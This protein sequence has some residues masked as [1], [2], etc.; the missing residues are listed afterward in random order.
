MPAPTQSIIQMQ[1]SGAA[2]EWTDVSTDVWLADYPLTL[3]YG[4]PG[5]SP[6]DRVAETGTCTFALN[7]SARNTAKIAGYYS[8]GG[9]RCRPGFGYGIGVRVVFTYLGVTYYKFRGVIDAIQPMPGARGGRITVCTVVD[10]IDEAARY[11]LRGIPAQVDQ[12]SDEVVSTILAEMPVQPAATSIDTGIDTFAYSLDT[13]DD[14]RSTA[15]SEFQKIAQ[16]EL[17]YI[18]IKGDSTQGGTLVFENRHHRSSVVTNAVTLSDTMLAMDVVR[19]RDELLNTVTVTVQPRRVGGSTVVLFTLN[20][21]VVVPPNGGTITLVCPYSDPDN[22]AEQIGG[23]NMIA[24]VATTDYTAVDEALPILAL[25]TYVS[26]AATFGGNSASVLFT[27]SH[28]TESALIDFFQLRGEGVFAFTSES[29]L[30]KA[31][32]TTSQALL[33]ENGLSLDMPY[34]S[35]ANTGQ[36]AANYLLSLYSD[37]RTTARSVTFLANTS[38]ALLVAALAREIGDRVGIE[39][40]VTGLTDDVEWL[41]QELYEVGGT[42]PLRASSSIQ[43]VAQGFKCNP[44]A[45]TRVEFQFQRIGVPSGVVWAQIESD[46]AG[47]PSGTALATSETIRSID[48]QAGD[49]FWTTFRFT[50]PYTVASASTQYHLVL[51]STCSIDGTNYFSLSGVFGIGLYPNG[52]GK[53]YNG[54]AW[55]LTNNLNFKLYLLVSTATRGYFINNI[56]LRVPSRHRVTCTWGLTPADSTRYWNLETAGATE[57]DATT[58]LA[59]V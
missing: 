48:I 51:Y 55:S 34:Q 13:V 12:R 19:D 2:G 43:R 35:D 18:Y 37:P 36:G 28:Q 14:Q 4:L 47:S 24:P 9:A 21:E 8:P 5:S 50:T 22:N 16:S 6:V 11:R 41:D 54:S 49:Y 15:L 27:N 42:L 23:I 20:S 26:V 29:V 39:E 25:T 46:S 58:V 57:L 33:G 7:N 53:G 38:S 31:E 59:Y 1:F 44:G 17:G 52:N 45:I 40:T 32:D 3:R 10:W 56:E 30:L